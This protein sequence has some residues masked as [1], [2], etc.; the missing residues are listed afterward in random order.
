MDNYKGEHNWKITG[1]LLQR[2]KA[3]KRKEKFTSTT[4]KMCNLDWVIDINPNGIE[5]LQTK[6]FFFFFN[7]RIK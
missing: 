5:D 1:D 6:F 7:P 2:L 3:A 4:F